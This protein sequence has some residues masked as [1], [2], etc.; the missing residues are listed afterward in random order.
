M[1]ALTAIARA[2]FQE[3]LGALAPGL[4]I[5][6]GLEIKGDAL[7]IGAASFVLFPKQPVYAVAL[8]KAARP[9]AEALGELLGER[10]S[11]GVASM[12]ESE[13]RLITPSDG[14]GG[15]WRVF[16]AGHPAPNEASLEA[17]QG[18]FALLRR[19][20]AE[21]ATVIFLVSGG[22]S[23]MMER[24]LD[25][26]VTLADMQSANRLL[27]N[28]GATI[29]EVNSVRRALSAIKGGGLAR[30]APN[31]RK[32]TLIIS[33]TNP[34]D[35]ANVASGPT[36]SPPTDA[37]DFQ[38]VLRKYNLRSLLPPSVGA[39]LAGAPGLSAEIIEGTA[40]T[41][42]DQN[43]ALAAASAS[44]ARRG[45][46]VTVDRE[47]VEQ[48]VSEGAG[49][50]FDEL[51]SLINS[52]ASDNVKRGERKVALVSAGEF[53]CPAHGGGQGGRSSETA[54]RLALLLDEKKAWLK[55][56]GWEVAALCGGTDGI[57]GNSPAAGAVAT[58]QTVTQAKKL[59]LNPAEHLQN[60]D[61][62]GFFAALGDAIITGPTGT[63]ARDLRILLAQKSNPHY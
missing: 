17:A 38:Q 20:D 40:F 23:A 42:L 56:K 29:A 3:T 33:D 24:P 22:G 16:G 47:I 44:L 25:S 14:L 36:L 57:D 2:V 62:H 6:K 30:A 21:Q 52:H 8:G 28:C 46:A 55:Q 53:A 13:A 5:Q 34:G 32:I 43:D 41:L 54:L 37:P 63:N 1:N 15:R 45:F 50:L 12:P 10:L 61:S 48:E 49:L 39:A 7:R 11:A 27:V 59:K 51:I 35:K 58:E 18:A 26:R 31:A 19:A 60:S 4:A 9:M